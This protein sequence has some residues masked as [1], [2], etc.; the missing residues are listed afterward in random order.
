MTAVSF[1]LLRK[2]ENNFLSH[3]P[4]SEYALFRGTVVSLVL[5]TDMKQHLAH[6]STLKTRTAHT[7]LV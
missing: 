5:A 7:K 1:R 4:P 2:P 3:M 6:V